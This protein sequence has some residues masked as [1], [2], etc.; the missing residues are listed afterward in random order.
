MYMH[1]DNTNN[2]VYNDISNNNHNSSSNNTHNAYIFDINANM[3]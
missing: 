1:N 3:I 2:N